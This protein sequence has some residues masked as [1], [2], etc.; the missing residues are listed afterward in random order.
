MLRLALL[1]LL[2]LLLLAWNE[3]LMEGVG[4]V[5]DLV[6][7]IELKGST[8]LEKSERDDKLLLL[9]QLLPLLLLLLLL[10]LQRALK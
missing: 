8:K 7:A 3:W 6:E 10:L 4:V 2:L 5:C 9:L 1:L